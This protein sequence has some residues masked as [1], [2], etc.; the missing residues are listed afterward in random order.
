MTEVM[1]K[2]ECGPF[3]HKCKAKKK[4]INFLTPK[5]IG[6]F[7]QFIAYCPYHEAGPRAIHVL[8]DLKEHWAGNT[9]TNMSTIVDNTLLILEKL[10][11][12]TA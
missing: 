11:K 1:K 10:D 2:S 3:M 5:R 8:Q 9:S 4:W 6:N 12:G 7:D